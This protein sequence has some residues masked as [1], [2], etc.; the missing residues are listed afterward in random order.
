MNWWSIIKQKPDLLQII[1][2]SMS[3]FKNNPKWQK[4]D[5]FY[6]NDAK[7]LH[8][9]IIN[10]DNW[11]QAVD[12]KYEGLGPVLKLIGKAAIK[13]RAFPPNFQENIYF[14]PKEIQSIK[15]IDRDERRNTARLSGDFDRQGGNLA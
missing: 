14:T 9:L 3:L 5:S 6:P 15:I 2:E 1:E 7:I 11:Q 8:G 12:N 4:Y 10:D 13:G